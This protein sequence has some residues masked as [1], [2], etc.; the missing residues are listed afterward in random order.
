MSISQPELSLVHISYHPVTLDFNCLTF[1]N[2]VVVINISCAYSMDFMKRSQKRQASKSSGK[3]RRGTGSFFSY[4]NSHKVSFFVMAIF[5]GII[6]VIVY[7]KQESKFSTH[8]EFMV[9]GVA[10]KIINRNSGKALAVGGGSVAR[11]AWIIQWVNSSPNQIEQQWYF[12]PVGTAYKVKNGKSNMLLSISNNIKVE[13]NQLNQWSDIGTLP[14][15]WSIA[16]VTKGYYRF[17]SSFNLLAMS[18]EGSSKLNGAGVNT[19]KWNGGAAEEWSIVPASNPVTV[20]TPQI[21]PSIN[22]GVPSSVC[23]GAGINCVPTPG[24]TITPATGPT[25]DPGQNPGGPNNPPAGPTPDPGQNPGGPNNP[26]SGGTIQQ[27]LHF[28]LQIL[29]LLRQ[30]FQH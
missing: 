11:G 21:Q 26:G 30:L 1:N 8:A 3:S 23:G 17:T 10:Y 18:V 16:S 12:I 24:P 25:P 13:G 2:D 29:E 22:P 7:G 6:A 5:L 20:P 28:I 4:R 14:Q 9:P 27:I 19:W 15:R